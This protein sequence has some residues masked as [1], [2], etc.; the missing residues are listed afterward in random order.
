MSVTIASSVRSGAAYIAASAI[1]FS[2]VVCM[3]RAW[4]IYHELVGPR[5]CILRNT[6]SKTI[7]AS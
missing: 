5:T 6:A 4:D 2:R 3:A 1:A 7:L